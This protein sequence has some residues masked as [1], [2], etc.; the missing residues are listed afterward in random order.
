[1]IK[2][3]IKKYIIFFRKLIFSPQKSQKTLTI[4]LPCDDPQSMLSREIISINLRSTCTGQK[5]FNNE[6]KT[7]FFTTCRD[8]LCNNS[9]PLAAIPNKPILVQFVKVCWS[10]WFVIWCTYHRFMPRYSEIHRLK[11]HFFI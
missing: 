2:K 5:E 8:I 4:F 3:Y 10:L 1:M 6:L 11:K 9:I 7:H